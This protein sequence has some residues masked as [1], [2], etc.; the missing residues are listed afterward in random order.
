MNKIKTS[1][2][3]IA[4]LAAILISVA[5]TKLPAPPDPCYYR[6]A[7]WACAQQTTVTAHRFYM[8]YAPNGCTGMSATR[9]GASVGSSGGSELSVPNQGGTY[10]I[11]AFNG[12]CWIQFSFV[13][14]DRG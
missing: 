4:F 3:K 10:V 14:P 2:A 1:V 5:T 7:G 8:T 9:N 11:T 6:T 13:Y 12:S